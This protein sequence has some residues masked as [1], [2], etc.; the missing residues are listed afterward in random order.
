MPRHP[1]PRTLGYWGLAVWV[2]C[3]TCLWPALP[4]L[5][6]QARGVI[7]LA[8]ITGVFAGLAAVLGMPLLT[9][10]SGGTGLLNLTVALLLT[11]HPPDFWGGLSAGLLL[12]ALLDSHQCWA[13]A[14]RCQV[15]PGVVRTLLG[16][17]LRL[18]SVAV[19]GSLMLAVIVSV[20]TPL[21]VGL[22]TAGM[23][24][25]AGAILFIGCF[26]A[27]LYTTSQGTVVRNLD[28]WDQTSD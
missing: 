20:F 14:R 13:Y 4:L 7:A 18:S 27:F 1:W 5:L 21:L 9:A 15:A 10:W 12:L 26:A 19:A 6:S 25:I 28:A 23:V 2:A 24:T 16:A 8:M 11:A 17:S 3:L 22:A